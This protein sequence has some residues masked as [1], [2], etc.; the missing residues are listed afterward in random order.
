MKKITVQVDAD[1]QDLVPNYLLNRGKDVQ[2]LTEHLKKQE[3][4]I[5]RRLGHRMK[6]SGGG[7]GLK[8]VTE[9]GAAIELAALQLDSSAVTEQIQALDD[10][11][12]RLEVIYV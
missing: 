8:N 1:L 9:I 3:F 6:G 12:A 11:L 4:E 10:Y 7:Y 5:I 2:D